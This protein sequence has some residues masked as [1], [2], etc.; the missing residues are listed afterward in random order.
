VA[1]AAL[2]EDINVLGLE[3]RDALVVSANR[4]RREVGLDNCFFLFSNANVDTRNICGEVADFAKIRS[5][6]IQFPDPHFKKRN[7]KRRVVSLP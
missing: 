4:R 6:S 5:F 7:H 3:I 2:H 1:Y